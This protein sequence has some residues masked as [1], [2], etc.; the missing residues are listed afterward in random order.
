MTETQEMIKETLEAIAT[1]EREMEK[2]E[3]QSKEWYGWNNVKQGCENSMNL[4]MAR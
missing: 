3:Y 2:V 1:C 4:L